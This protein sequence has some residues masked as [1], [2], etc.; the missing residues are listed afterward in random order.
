MLPITNPHHV[1]GLRAPRL[2]ILATLPVVACM[3]KPAP[4]AD[5]GTEASYRRKT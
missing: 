1:S 5:R 4:A 2:A 3:P